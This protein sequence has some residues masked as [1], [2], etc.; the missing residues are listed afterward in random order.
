ME[1]GRRKSREVRRLAVGRK[2]QKSRSGKGNWQS[3]LRN[4]CIARMTAG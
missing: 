3:R 1:V 2:S 4:N